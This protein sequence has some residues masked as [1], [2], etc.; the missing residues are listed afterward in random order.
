MLSEA[1]E[2]RSHVDAGWRAELNKPVTQVV[3]NG[4]GAVVGVVSYAS[5]ARDYT[6]QLLWLHCREDESMADALIRHAVTSPDTTADAS[7]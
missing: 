4:A 7:T 5:R 1:L 6:G 2:G 3:V